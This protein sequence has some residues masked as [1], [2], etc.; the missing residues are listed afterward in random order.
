MVD[1]YELLIADEQGQT[2]ARNRELNHLGLFHFAGAVMWVL[3]E[4]LGLQRE[5]M[6]VA[7]DE[8]RGRVLL[9]EILNGGNFGKYDKKYGGITRQSPARKL[10]TKVRRS[11]LLARLYPAEALSVPWF[12]VWC[13]GWKL[14]HRN[15]FN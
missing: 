2:A 5:K 14:C 1:Y 7:P 15:R 12:L 3:G 4:I 6:I 13:Y 11:L 8:R 9:Q 10:L